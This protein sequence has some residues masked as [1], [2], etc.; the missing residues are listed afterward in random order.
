[1]KTGVLATDKTIGAA[2]AIAGMQDLTK[3]T[4]KTEVSY[5]EDVMN[6][7]SAKTVAV[8]ETF[9]FFIKGFDI[10]TTIDK[11]FDQKDFIT[12]EPLVSQ[13]EKRLAYEIIYGVLRNKSLLDFAVEKYLAAP[14]REEEALKV[15]LQIGAYQILY[16]TKIP[17]FAA[18][19]ESVNLCKRHSQTSKFSD[20]TNAVLRK[21]I[22]EKAASRGRNFPEIS[23]SVPF[24]EKIAI[25]YSHPLWLVE[26]WIE[27]FGKTPT[28]KILQFNNTIPD[29]FIRRN[30]ALTSK[31]KFEATVAK[32]CANGV[33]RGV[34][35]NGLYYKLQAGER[36]DRNDLFLSGQCTVQAPSSGWVVALLDVENGKKILDLCAAPGGK[37]TLLSE[38]APNS[39]IVAADI[40]FSRT[41]MISDTLKRLS[42]RNVDIVA[43][44]AKSLGMSQIFDFCLIDAPCS[45]TGVINHHPEARWLRDEEAIEKAAARQKEILKSAVQTVDVGGIIVYSTC[46]LENEENRAQVETFLEENP[47]F[48]LIPAKEK[49]K[50]GQ[51]L[52]DNGDFLEITPNK[53]GADAIFA[54]RF[55]RV[56]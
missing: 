47:N 50:D 17:D 25:E 21:L 55:Q 1:V 20:L 56:E 36:I 52:S 2:V 35:F 26:R 38:V 30:V 42:I 49:I 14:V 54:A 44:D 15:I 23:N 39:Q 34:G 27:Q 45:A 19:N 6:V 10:E 24:A 40:S 4:I 48:V 11:L 7:H 53:N 31:N 28:Q 13:T 8:V 33:A 12:K 32:S 41:K 37:T 5:Q 3:E 51:L 16:L 22:A 43:A 29:I 18:V 46:S 9:K